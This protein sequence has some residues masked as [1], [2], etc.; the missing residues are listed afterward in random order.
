M[1]NRC[2]GQPAQRTFD[3]EAVEKRSKFDLRMIAMR[4]WEKKDSNVPNWMAYTEVVLH[5]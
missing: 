2:L 5:R 3:L 1:C 4:L